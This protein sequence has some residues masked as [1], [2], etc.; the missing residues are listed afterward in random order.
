MCILLIAVNGGRFLCADTI[1]ERISKIQE[2]KMAMAT[3][4]LNGVKHTGGSKLTI[5]DMK[6][7]FDM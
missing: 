2:T 4:M 6:A 1:E 5:D 7:L 3:D